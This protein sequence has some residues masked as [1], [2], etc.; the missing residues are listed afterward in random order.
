MRP[1]VAAQTAHSAHD[2]PH[3]IS[4][5]RQSNASQA[6]SALKAGRITASEFLDL[7]WQVGGWKQPSEMVQEGFPFLGSISPATFDPWSRRNMNLAPSA[8]SPAPRTQ[9]SLDAMRAAYSSGHVFNGQLGVPAIDHRQYMERELDMHNAHQS[10]AVRKR[11]QQRMGSSDNLVIWFTDTTPGVAK[12]SQSLDALDVMDQW[13][14]NIRAN[15]DRS[16]AQ[17]KPARAVDSCFDLQGRQLHAGA[18]VWA[19]I[20]DTQPAGACTQAFPLY[21]TSR[22]VAGAP[23]EGAI[24][25]CALKT[26]DAAVA[27]G[28]FGPWVPSATETSRLKAIF[29]TGVCDYSKADRA[30]PV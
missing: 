5:Q 25:A 30:K 19:G 23:L 22:I 18:G 21:S 4:R 13:M 1:L 24:Y 8:S 28:T 20:L 29:P 27:D 6:L 2:Q 9:G 3:S 11:V 7:N 14:A 10:F 15:P 17:N 12:F 16:I 26:V